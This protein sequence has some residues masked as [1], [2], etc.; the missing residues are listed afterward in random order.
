MALLCL[1]AACFIVLQIPAVQTYIGKKA[2]DSVS[3]KING[4]IS[5]GKIYLVFFNRVIVNDIAIVSTEKS[6][7]LDS[8]KANYGQ[9][10]TLLYCKKLSVTLKPVELLKFKL[11]LNTISLSGGEFNLQ[12]EKEKYTNLD[13]IFRLS[14]DAPKDTTRK[15]SPELLANALRIEDFRFTLNNPE[16]IGF[17]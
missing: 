1:Q 6:P 15:G 3:D 14:K 8:L 16:T 10:D 4:E 12:T 7:L 11:K 9:S 17:G 13:R 5:I 2:V